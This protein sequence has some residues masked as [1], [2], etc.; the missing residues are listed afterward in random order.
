VA[1]VGDSLRRLSLIQ[2]RIYNLLGDAWH[3]VCRKLSRRRR[4]RSGLGGSTNP[5]PVVSPPEIR[6]IDDGELKDESEDGYVSDSTSDSASE[7]LDFAIAADTDDTATPPAAA[8]RPLHGRLLSAA[9]LCSQGP[10]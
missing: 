4:R 5:P 3:A 9:V 2:H 7:E 8:A 10:L 6:I 1:N